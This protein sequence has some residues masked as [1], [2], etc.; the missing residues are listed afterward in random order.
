MAWTTLACAVVAYTSI[1][2]TTA[3]Y[4]G[5]SVDGSCNVNRALYH[6]DANG[7]WTPLGAFLGRGVAYFV[8]GL[9][10]LDVTS[11]YPLNVMVSRSRPQRL[12]KPFIKGYLFIHSLICF[13]SVFHLIFV[14]FFEGGGGVEFS[15]YSSPGGDLMNG[16]SSP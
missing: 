5:T 6:P 7:M 10:A 11:V 15:Y 3:Y 12:D 9:P 13:V 14:L 8:G 4:F 2:L 1:S 16:L